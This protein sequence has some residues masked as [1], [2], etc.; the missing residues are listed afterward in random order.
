MQ[1]FK[2]LTE[3][4][5]MG[6]EKKFLDLPLCD[7]D[8]CREIGMRLMAGTDDPAV[9]QKRFKQLCEF[10]MTEFY[11]FEGWALDDFD[12]ELRQEKIS[13]DLLKAFNGV[14][15]ACVV[16]DRAFWE[17]YDPGRIFF[18]EF[19]ASFCECAEKGWSCQDWYDRSESAKAFAEK[20]GKRRL[21][22]TYMKTVSLWRKK[23]EKAFDPRRDSFYSEDALKRL[24]YG[25]SCDEARDAVEFYLYHRADERKTLELCRRVNVMFGLHCPH[26]EF[27]K[28]Y[29]QLKGEL[30][31]DEE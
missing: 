6:L 28:E 15:P 13:A 1:Q 25:V 16:D 12:P 2:L 17:L 21:P 8:Y 7:A 5:F 14:L 29:E 9:L 10:C 23:P 20:Y 4:Y 18:G 27:V 26:R 11:E 3:R 19:K 22:L 31:E 24:L 30:D